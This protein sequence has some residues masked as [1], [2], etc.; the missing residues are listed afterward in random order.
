MS[1][2]TILIIAGVLLG[3]LFLFLLAGF[4]I[5]IINRS[6]VKT[7]V[8][9]AVSNAKP[10]S[11]NHGTIINHNYGSE[12]EQKEKL[13]NDETYLLI[14]RCAGEFTKQLRQSNEDIE[15]AKQ[16]LKK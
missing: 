16:R 9:E 1:V 2:T 8:R 4:F 7:A 5:W 6:T 3:F 10:T 14:S 11:I 15:P 12:I 13:A